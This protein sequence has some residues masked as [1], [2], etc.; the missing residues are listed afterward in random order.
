[1]HIPAVGTE[2]QISHDRASRCEGYYPV[3]AGQKW[4]EKVDE[5]VVPVRLTAGEASKSILGDPRLREA[6][7]LLRTVQVGETHGDGTKEHLVGVRLEVLADAEHVVGNLLQRIHHVTRLSEQALGTEATRLQDAVVGLE[8]LLELLFDYVSP[9]QVCMSETGAATIA[10]SL[11]AEIRSHAPGGVM[12]GEHPRVPMVADRRLLSRSFQLL[13]QACGGEW[14]V[15]RRVAVTV[16]H[17]RSVRRVEFCINAE[18]DRRPSGPG[19]AQLALAV[20]SRLIDLHGG[21]LCCR[22]STTGMT[23]SFTL[24]T[25]KPDDECG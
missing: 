14:R 23:W 21:A 22:S 6:S 19:E 24:P 2:C 16:G 3:S 10:D 12:L 20:A 11:L 5:R 13:G 4:L 1:M 8:R 7:E 25:G 15:A 18:I 9:I 17:N